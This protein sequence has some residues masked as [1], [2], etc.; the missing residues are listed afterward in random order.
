[1][2]ISLAF[3]ILFSTLTLQAAEPLKIGNDIQL[4]WDKS[5]I[6]SQVNGSFKYHRPTPKE[7]SLTTDAP[8]EGNVSA[9]FTFLQDG[10]EYRAYY[11]GS[12]YDTE[13]KVVTHRE[14]TCVAVSKDGIK[15]TKP[16][17]G[18][19]E[20]DGSKEN[21][22]VW[23]GIGTHCFAPFVDE[24]PACPKNERYKAVSRGRY[25]T[26]DF[27]VPDRQK[28]IV[29]LYMFTSEDGIRWKLKTPKPV[30]TDGAFDSQNIAFWDTN[31]S[32]YVCYSRLFINGVRAIQY[33]ESEDFLNWSKPAPI[34]YAKE[35]REHLYTNAIQQY[36]RNPKV[37]IGL[38]TRFLPKENSRVEPIF[39]HSSDGFKF[40]RNQ[41][42]FIPESFPEDRSGNRSN[43]ACR[44]VLDLP[45][46]DKTHSIYATEAYYTGAD[47]RVRRFELRTD[48]FM[49]LS[50]SGQAQIVTKPVIVEGDAIVLNSQTRG[51][52]GIWVDLL[53]ENNKPI[54]GF[55]KHE[56]N[57]LGGDSIHNEVTWK[58]G[59]TLKELQGKVVK[60][61]IT[62][63]STDIYSL[64]IK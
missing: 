56:A 46:S 24:N 35:Y 40:Y 26:G 3:L 58:N 48:G 32:K 19:Y 41:H 30:I 10:D 39:M 18:L 62:F 64:Q 27:D 52:G 5:L 61:H 44:G 43:Y 12:H 2:R 55:T 57:G 42:P 38:P 33:C 31:K 34:A 53:D 15:W 50:T 9:Y 54:P 45:H 17:L 49:S 7:V 47:S 22:I 11:R 51:K 23:D 60:I 28:G 1:M 36:Q 8:W 63:S 29:G 25:V 59:R 4:L 16:K 20:F 6:E 21:N 14:V 37:Y 13:R